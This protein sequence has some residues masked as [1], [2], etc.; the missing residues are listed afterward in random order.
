MKALAQKW[1]EAGNANYPNSVSTHMATDSVAMIG[2]VA[3][4]ERHYQHGRYPIP[5]LGY[6]LCN[7][8]RVTAGLS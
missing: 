3:A 5:K 1:N 4:I 7:A 6:S 8:P 2:R